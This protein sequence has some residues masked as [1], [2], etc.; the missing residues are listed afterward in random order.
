MLTILAKLLQFLN[1]NQNPSQFALAVCFG[2]AIGLMPGFSLFLL[3][4]LMMVCL[5]K[6]NISILLVVWGLFE[7][8][9]Y[10]VDPALHQVGYSILTTESLQPMWTSLSQSS[11]WILT[12]FNN[13]LV[14]G[15]TVAIIILW[16]PVYFLV[17]MLVIQYREQVQDV[18]KQLKI[19]QLL[20]GSKFFHVYQRLGN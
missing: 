12:A 3:I 9:A 7:A 8:I 4:L 16:L 15:S 17:R 14:M 1:S 13:S 19:T 18:F 10:I 11:F 5:I 20:K 2:F 6:A